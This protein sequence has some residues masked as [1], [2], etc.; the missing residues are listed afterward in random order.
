MSTGVSVSAGLGIGSSGNI[1]GSVGTLE[2]I[3]RQTLEDN[4]YPLLLVLKE[5]ESVSIRSF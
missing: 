5:I 1:G 3:I 2:S 4:E